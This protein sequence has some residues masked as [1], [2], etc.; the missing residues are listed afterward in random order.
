MF[1]HYLKIAFRHLIRNK[2]YA[3][4][5]IMG[6]AIG[7]SSCILIF[8]YVQDEL[9]FD[10]YHKDKDLIYR[11]SSKLD[12]NGEVDAAVSSFAL[13][14][15][16]VKDFPE[17][18]QATRFSPMG[19]NTEVRIKDQIFKEA[20]FWLSDSTLFDVFT[21]QSIAGSLKNALVAPNS[22]VL[23]RS[24]A[25]KYFERTDCVGEQVKINNQFFTVKAIIEDIPENSEI[26]ATAFASFSTLPRQAVSTFNQ[27]WFRISFFT[28]L[29]FREKP[30]VDEFEEKLKIFEEKYVQPWAKQNDVVA[31]VTYTIT[32]LED[33]HFDRSK[34]YDLPKGNISYIY[35]FSLLALFIL[36]IASI[37][38]INLSLA[39]GSKRAKEIGIRKS[40][41]AQKGELMKQ[42][43]GESVLLA[44]VAGIIALCLVEVFLDSF[45]Q[46]A[47]KSFDS[48]IIFSPPILYALIGII[49]IISFFGGGYPAL[50]LSS[51]NPVKILKGSIPNTGKI[52]G[53]KKGLILVQFIFSIFMITGTILINSQMDYL[54]NINLGFDQEN[55]ISINLP[56]DTSVLKKV[57][58]WIDELRN[59]TQIKAL[60]TS[61]LPSGNSSS[62]ILF[63]IEQEKKLVEKT[64]KVLFV[65][66]DFLK[67]LGIK[68]KE[69]R[70]FSKEIQT[71]QQQAFII[72]EE[73]AK[74]YGWHDQALNKRLQWGLLPNGQ[75][76]NDG[77]VVGVVSNFNFM[78]L[79]NK[80]E[81][82]VLAYNPNGNNT[83]S[84]RLTSGD[85]I[86]TISSLE[87]RWKKI[88]PLYPFA[89]TFM[90]ENLQQNY[91]DETRMHKIFSYFAI[92]SV[93]IASL[94]LFALVSFTIES[95]VKEI[96]VR[97]VLGASVFQ[98]LWILVKD[99]FTLLAIA[100]VIT[101]PINIYL[102]NKWLEGFAYHVGLNPI[103][104]IQSILI[105]TS[106]ASITISYHTLVIQKT[107]PVK[108]LRYE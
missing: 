93:V 18:D 14:P 19:N 89:C 57:K 11:I 51:F 34:N 37:N 39:Q 49:F 99:F 7:I 58:P 76:T 33:L 77:K 53:L 101:T 107:D 61:S 82:L 42:F 26:K 29:K 24:I 72:N 103:S 54:K 102:M 68:L 96:G 12:F 13:A 65:D 71:D 55:L 67:V 31:K 84:I 66:E 46:L 104:F 27:D 75:A 5:S 105:T 30:N 64:V 47:N 16:L 45:N 85:Y 59:N 48:G 2:V 80:L 36:I 100:F 56:S 70:N 3:L 97:K 35:V 106:L 79:H 108:A 95:K 88:A 63:R 78:S 9:N 43:L 25:L 60:S 92:I 20:N 81:P 21:Y 38:Y 86:S 90:D 52:G 41:G 4:I 98:I 23:T 87:D 91:R 6:L 10:N 94:G 73:A 28:F 40:L 83:L 1:L 32:S 69:G 17:I 22:I 74:Q 15:T 62:E 44:I 50:V 8:I